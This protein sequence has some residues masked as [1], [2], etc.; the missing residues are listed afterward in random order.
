MKATVVVYANSDD[1]LL[2][3][4]A[5]QLEDDLE[6]FSVQRKLQRGAAA[7]KTSWIDNYAPPGVK[8]YQDGRHVPSDQRPFRTFTWTDHEVQA[9]DK[10]RYRVV[11]FLAGTTAPA[12]ELASAWSRRR[13]VGAPSSATNRAFFNRGFV[14]SQFISRYLDEHYP[15]MDRIAALRKFKAQISTKLD[16]QIRVF[17]SGEVRTAPLDLLT[18]VAKSSDEIYAA[19]LFE[20]ADDE[21]VGE[22]RSIGKRAHVVLANGSIEIKKDKKTNKALE[23]TEQARKRDENSAARKTLRQAGVDIQTTNRFVA[24]GALAH[25]KFLVVTDKKGKAKSVWTGST[26]WTTTGLCT[27]LNNALLVNDSAV[28]ASYLAQ[29]HALRDAGSSHPQTLPNRTRHQRM[30][31]ASSP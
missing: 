2:L 7:E 8:A 23:T 17:L 31:V 20:L 4:S 22:L 19:L 14:I 5:D 1:A 12:T 16:D 9:G 3:W 21:L 28:A 24:P 15:N 13:T 27:Q 30:W 25:N 11:P 10:V 29:W 6:G 18:R 26:N